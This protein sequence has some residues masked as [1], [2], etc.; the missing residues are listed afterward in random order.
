MRLNLNTTIIKD[1]KE[2]KPSRKKRPLTDLHFFDIYIIDLC[3]GNRMIPES[4]SSLHKDTR[5]TF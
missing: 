4:A 3:P 2:V 1:R 5:Q